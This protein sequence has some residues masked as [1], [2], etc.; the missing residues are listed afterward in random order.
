MRKQ[1]G[2]RKQYLYIKRNRE[3][4]F[5]NKHIDKQRNIN[6]QKCANNAE[7]SSLASDANFG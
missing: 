2:K 3:K 1:K 6:Q 5:R 7:G 4:L